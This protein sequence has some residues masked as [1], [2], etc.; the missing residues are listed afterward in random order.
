MSRS[1]GPASS[2]Q[3][4][5]DPDHRWALLVGQLDDLEPEPAASGPGQLH[6]GA[7]LREQ[8]RLAP[9]LEPLHHGLE[10]D[11]R[12]PRESLQLLVTMDPP[13]EI[14]LAKPLDAQPLRDIDEVADLDRVAGEERDRLEERPAAR[15]LPGERLDEAGQLRVEEVDQRP[16]DE[17]RDPAAAA[18]L[19]GAAFHDRS[20]VVALDVLQTWLRK[21]RPCGATSAVRQ[22]LL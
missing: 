20:L 1:S 8:A 11:E 15:V 17:L 16:R 10:D 22:G 9:L 4:L 13:L 6:R 21:E 3:V 14:H 2:L 12:H 7:E 19:E 5:G 18:L